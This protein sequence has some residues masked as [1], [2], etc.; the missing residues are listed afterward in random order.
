MINPAFSLS[1]RERWLMR[2][3]AALDDGNA[4][5]LESLLALA[6]DDAEFARLIGEVHGTFAQEHELEATAQFAQVGELARQY[7]APDATQSEAVR[8]DEV[9]GYLLQRA[10]NDAEKAQ[11]QPFLASQTPLPLR[12][13]RANLEAL[14]RKLSVAVDEKFLRRFKDAAITVRMSRTT[15]Q[16]QLALA[17][18]EKRKR[19]AEA[20]TDV[21]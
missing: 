19:K 15:P 8:V 10:A 18:Q 14:A 1:E 4:S 11:L 6:H 12:L 21:D 20:T 13:T 16:S 3:I 9:A 17:R 7:L 2:Y 5:A